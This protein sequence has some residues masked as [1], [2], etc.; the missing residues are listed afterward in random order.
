MIDT[1]R[2][3]AAVAQYD[4]YGQSRRLVLADF[5]RQLERELADERKATSTLREINKGI[6]HDMVTL[7]EKLVEAMHERDEARENLIEAM[8]W[9]QTT[10]NEAPCQWRRW[11]KAAGLGDGQ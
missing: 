1:P 3:D 9:S 6:M 11:R 10:P 7:A 4:Q 5:A 2:T 8:D